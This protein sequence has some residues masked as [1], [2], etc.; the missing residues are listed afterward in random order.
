MCLCGE[1]RS[2]PRLPAGQGTFRGD[3]TLKPGAFQEPEPF[4]VQKEAYGLAIRAEKAVELDARN[5]VQVTGSPNLSEGGERRMKGAS[6]V[7]LGRDR[8]RFQ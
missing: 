2:A 3:V 6:V 5:V 4:I 1:H 7:L 8:G